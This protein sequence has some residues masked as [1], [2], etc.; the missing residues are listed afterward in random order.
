MAPGEGRGKG[1]VKG[2][3][4]VRPRRKGFGQVLV[5]GTDGEGDLQ[6]NG[7]RKINGRDRK[8]E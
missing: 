1:G 3:L 6:E 8:S 2:V 5:L 4:V 7:R